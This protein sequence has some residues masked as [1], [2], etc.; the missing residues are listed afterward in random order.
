MELQDGFARLQEASLY[1]VI[2]FCTIILN[3]HFWNQVVTLASTFVSCGASGGSPSFLTKKPS[4][5]WLRIVY[6]QNDTSVPQYTCMC[7]CWFA[8]P[9]LLAVDRGKRTWRKYND[10]P[11]IRDERMENATRDLKVFRMR[12]LNMLTIL[13]PSKVYLICYKTHCTT[14]RRKLQVRQRKSLAT[15]YHYI[16]LG[17]F[18]N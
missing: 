15:W 1:T 18:W 11:W 13:C 5:E 12:D 2:R 8:W 14:V 6:P 3:L 10:W 17:E 4:Y 7:F 16:T 9:Y